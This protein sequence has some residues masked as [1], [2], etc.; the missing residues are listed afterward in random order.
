MS[1][2]QHK[3]YQD[4]HE[5]VELMKK[6]DHGYD[7]ELVE[8][9]YRFAEEKHGDQ[10]RASG[11]PYILHPTSVA[12]I[13][14]EL[15]MDTESIAAALLHDVVEDTPVTL[16]EI[17]SLFGHEIAGLIDGVTTLG[18][19]PYSSRE[20]QQAENIR[21][22]LIAMSNDIRVIII[23]LADRLHNMRTLEC[24]KEQHRRD[25][26][27][28]VMDVYAPIAHRLGIR[29][30]KEELED[31][32]IRYLDPVGY[33][34]IE[35]QLENKSKD[36]I[37]FVAEIKQNLYER[38]KGEINNVYISGRVK[39][40]HGIYK[41]TF[42]KGK[43]LDQI[44]DIFAVRVIVDSVADCYNVLG[45]VHDMY[46]PLPN[47]FK[48]YISTPKPNMYQS[49]HT[50]VIG[51]EGVP[52]EI[53]IRTWE[54]HYTAEYGIAAHWKYKEGI[55][56]KDS[57]DERLAWIRKMLENQ[58]DNDSTDIVRTIKM[59][60]VPEEVFIFT[61]KGDVISLPAGATVIDVAYAIHSGVGNRMI[62]AKVDKRI[63]PIDY[64]VKT[65]EIVEII[66]SKEEGGPKR[67]WLNIVKTSEA[68]S[69]IRLWFK[70]EKRDENI[71]EGRTQLETEF[72]RLNIHVP[73]K[74]LEE[75]LADIIRRQNCN[76]LEDF[77]AS[78]GYGGIQ[79]WRILPKL[80]EEYIKRYSEP[81]PA[82]VVIT[83][84]ARK[85]ISGG[86]HIE[87]IDDCLVKYSRCCN[88]LPGDEIIGFITRGY[89]VS[90]HKR[91]CS[92]VPKNIMDC[93][94]PERWVKAEWAEHISNETFQSTLQITATDRTGL[95]ADITNQ[96]S[97]MHL[98]IHA[99]N[100]REA[101]NGM[102]VV[103]ITITVN[104]INHL[105][106]VISRLSGI[107]GIVSIGR[108]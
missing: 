23:K 82:P 17:V 39:S 42:V 40:I 61:P 22:M 70:R 72:R 41:K 51:K 84:P 76:S 63:V 50:T 56:K 9:A 92:N 31:L 5:L 69:K 20:E 95:L 66:T 15:G 18:K 29:A 46:K 64:R 94:E 107:N 62:G 24:M 54:M 33:A 88:P 55:T 85:K 30:I 65:G 3:Y 104:G 67:D 93:E 59:D 83:E 16:D 102:A 34:E 25:K 38:L 96:L 68:R 32:S 80:K 57:L 6:S 37:N 47:R 86:V 90:I 105:R 89:G 10:R 13:L 4:Y 98:F 8:K 77:Y 87:G 36:R 12:C 78:I 60:L 14:A 48:D 28:E 35:R 26:A 27:L 97:A 75:F 79:L 81:E 49:L 73:E 11:I 52:F 19:I 71:V 45:I 2:I 43:T 1:E 103:E 100:S 99:L 108:A 53:Q 58:S 106:S 21:K 101:K 7:F 44:F 74:E 91:T